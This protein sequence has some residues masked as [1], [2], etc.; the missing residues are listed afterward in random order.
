MTINLTGRSKRQQASP[1]SSRTHDDIL[2]LPGELSNQK[3]TETSTILLNINAMSFFKTGNMD[4]LTH[5]LNHHLYG[6]PEVKTIEKGFNTFGQI[7]L[8]VIMMCLFFRVLHWLLVFFV[9][10]T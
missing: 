5:Y 10:Y 1:S 3:E 4:F 2:K 9:I 7:L 6:I 8:R